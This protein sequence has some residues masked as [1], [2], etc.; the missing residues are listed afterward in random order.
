MSPTSAVTL[1]PKIYHS[2]YRRNGKGARYNRSYMT[3]C[4]I[5][6]LD[7]W[8]KS[9][10][11]SLIIYPETVSSDVNSSVISFIRCVILP[12]KNEFSRMVVH[13]WDIC[14]R[15]HFPRPD[16]SNNSSKIVLIFGWYKSSKICDC[17]D[18]KIMSHKN[19]SGTV[20]TGPER[21]KPFFVLFNFFF[22]HFCRSNFLF[23]WICLV[24][25]WC[26]WNSSI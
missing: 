1:R 19:D 3:L 4:H 15:N 13:N 14:R 9:D 11:V 21:Q 7:P 26:H 20:S 25:Y 22:R 2:P 23:Q 18:S 6:K 10:S 24:L 5:K 12:A 8:G 17:N 16:K